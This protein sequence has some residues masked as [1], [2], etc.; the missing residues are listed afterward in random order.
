MAVEVLLLAAV[1]IRIISNPISNV[2]QKNL[3]LSLHHPLF[4]N[5]LSYL[6]LSMFS[7]FLLPGHSLTDLN[8]SF[9]IYSVLSGVA[10]A[11]GNAFIIKALEKGD[12]SVLGPIN[13]YKSVIGIIFAFILLGELPNFWGFIGVMLIITGSYFV[14]STGQGKFSWSILKQ[15]A[16]KFRIAALVLTGIQAVFD[17]KIIQNSDLA[18]AFVSWC[19][20]GAL[21][22]YIICLL[23]G[24][25]PQYYFKGMN[26]AIAGKYL[27]LCASIAL[28]TASTNYT[29]KN[30]PVGEALA[31]FQISILISVFLGYKIFQEQGL[32]RKLIGSVIMIAGS[33]FIL[34]FK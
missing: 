29:F 4:V 27:A 20:F 32:I 6:V 31:L 9:W 16:I 21:F 17:K 15:P 11:F 24:V 8:S 12:L 25:K 14:L 3:T 34:L 23:N 30:M 18:M 33:L 26:R 7:L 13:A 22:S 1:T 2:I 28:M 10:G 19:T 5:F